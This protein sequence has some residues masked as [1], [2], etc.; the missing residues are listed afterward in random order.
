MK[1]TRINPQF[2]I[3]NYI[4]AGLIRIERARGS[5]EAAAL[6]EA[7]A[8]EMVRRPERMP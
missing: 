8:K 1:N 5:S 6:S 4:T 7:W 2:T 3:T